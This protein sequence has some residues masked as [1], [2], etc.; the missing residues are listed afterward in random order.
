[1]KIFELPRSPFSGFSDQ[2]CQKFSESQTRQTCSSMMPGKRT[3]FRVTWGKI[4]GSHTYFSRNPSVTQYRRGASETSILIGRKFFFA[5]RSL[6]LIG[7]NIMLEATHG[8]SMGGVVGCF[9]RSDRRCQ[10]VYRE[11]LKR[12][13]RNFSITKVVNDYF[14]N[15]KPM[16]RT[17]FVIFSDATQSPRRRNSEFLVLWIRSYEHSIFFT[18]DGTRV[19]PF[20][21]WQLRIQ[22]SKFFNIMC[23]N[24]WA[25]T[26]NGKTWKLNIFLYRIPFFSLSIFFLSSPWYH[27]RRWS[28][29]NPLNKTLMSLKSENLHPKF[30]D[31]NSVPH[32]YNSLPLLK[33]LH[34]PSFSLSRA[35]KANCESFSFLPKV[36]FEEKFSL[37]RTRFMRR[38][39]NIIENEYRVWLSW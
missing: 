7:E 9:F 10:S 11:V 26:N 13:I 19:H 23:Q 37:V 3:G 28:V 4:A 35:T 20:S 38:E 36:N 29:L 17:E 15:F 6:A 31:E 18:S 12:I 1:M 27:K 5:S 22:Y 30:V 34:S 14:I 2:K 21:R 16:H 24:L 8:I 25:F 39:E 33:V 32:S